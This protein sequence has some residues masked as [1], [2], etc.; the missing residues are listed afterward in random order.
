MS[1]A[2]SI[3]ERQD[4]PTIDDNVA[5]LDPIEELRAMDEQEN[6]QELEAIVGS[7]PARGIGP[8]EST[9]I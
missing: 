6:R 9:R 8:R 1:E 2:V 4:D 3:P 5:E 7:A